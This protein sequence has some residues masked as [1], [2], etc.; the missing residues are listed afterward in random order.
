MFD[1]A[2]TGS[3]VSAFL[4]ER[5]AEPVAT[6]VVA[7]AVRSVESGSGS[8]DAEPTVTVFVMIVPGGVAALKLTI[9][10]NE[11]VPVGVLGWEQLMLPV[12]PTAGVVHVQLG[13]A[14]KDTNVVLA[15]TVSASV[16]VVAL[17]GPELV[18]RM[19]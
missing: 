17:L 2:L 14:A 1:P 10:V 16:A 9:S 12:P 18:T 11:S 19:P 6:V 15:G 8:V 7:V 5:S 3:G 4:T 13:F